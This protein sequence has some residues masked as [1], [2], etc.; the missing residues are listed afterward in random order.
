[1]QHGSFRKTFDLKWGWFIRSSH[2][3]PMLRG[4][5]FL[6]W[7]KNCLQEQCTRQWNPWP[8]FHFFMT[9]EFKAAEF[10]AKCCGD[11]ILFPQQNAKM[12]MPRNQ[13][14]NLSPSVCWPKEISSNAPLTINHIW[15]ITTRQTTQPLLGTPNDSVPPG[16]SAGKRLCLWLVE[17]IYFVSG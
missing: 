10:H 3:S 5:E 16:P 15:P 13:K 17:K 12:G 11:T 14:R 6:S 7:S 2:T 1:M 4:R 8:F 9:Y